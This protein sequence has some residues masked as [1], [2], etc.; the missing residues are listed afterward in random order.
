MFFSEARTTK[1]SAPQGSTLE[2]FS[3]LLYEHNVI[4]SVLKAASYLHANDP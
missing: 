2:L 1:Y 3:F 4:Q